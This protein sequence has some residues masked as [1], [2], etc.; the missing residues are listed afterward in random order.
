M[1][2]D[3]LLQE[4]KVFAEALEAARRVSPNSAWRDVLQGMIYLVARNMNDH[5]RELRETK[6]H[7]SSE[8]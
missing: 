3:D 4:Y 7:Q 2:E 8:R 5:E 6:A 1:P